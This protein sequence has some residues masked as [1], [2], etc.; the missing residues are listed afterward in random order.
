MIFYAN[1]GGPHSTLSL[2]LI[3]SVA[4]NHYH[5]HNVRFLY[6]GDWFCLLACR[7]AYSP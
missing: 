7:M 3:G 2:G 6:L 5:N 4:A 1:N